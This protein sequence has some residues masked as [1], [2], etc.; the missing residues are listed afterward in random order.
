MVYIALRI[1]NRKVKIFIIL[2]SVFHVIIG[3]YTLKTYKKQVNKGKIYTFS[4][5]VYCF[6]GLQLVESILSEYSKENKGWEYSLRMR[7][8][9]A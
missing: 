5:I 1:I 7:R 6:P 2:I 3:N 9:P 4:H 8:L